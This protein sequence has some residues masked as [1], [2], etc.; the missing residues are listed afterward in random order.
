[1]GRK[2]LKEKRER[3]EQAGES[4]WQKYQRKRKEKRKEKKE[5]AK[6]K[7]QQGMI[8][9]REEDSEEAKRQKAS[10]EMMIGRKDNGAKEVKVNTKD[11][12]F[13]AVLGDKEFA[14]DPTHRNF[15][16]VADGEYIK[17]QKIKRRKMH[18]DE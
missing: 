15:R 1:M 14:L 16:K 11:S 4:E 5:Q 6:V 3:K 17:E 2:L 12:R 8:E 10:L 13:Q 7:K 18:Q 9:V